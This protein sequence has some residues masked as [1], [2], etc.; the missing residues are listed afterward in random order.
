LR[1]QDPSLA[2]SAIVAV[3]AAA[4]F[5]WLAFETLGA[6]IPVID[7]SVRAAVHAESFPALT[8]VMKALSVAGS[9]WFLWPL[10]ML[11]TAALARMGRR[12]DAGW[13]AI[14][15]LGANALNETMKLLFHRVR[16][17]PFFGYDKP[18]TFSYPSGHSFVSFCFYLAL[19]EVLARAE[20]PRGRRTALWL[21][22][23]L[24]V[25]GIGLS[26]IYLGVH[27]F[28]DVVGGYAGAAAWMTG[29]RFAHRRTRPP[30]SP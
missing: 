1:R 25:A 4:L 21:V 14:A 26:R 30:V 8:E 22:A 6:G 13:F 10:G 11:V 18:S 17:E 5:A 20:W 15:V 19:A 16:P 24:L 23:L 3:S 9:G 2:I 28:T 29:V 12:W 7:T 27:Y